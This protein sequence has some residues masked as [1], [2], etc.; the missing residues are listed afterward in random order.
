MEFSID[1]KVKVMDP[2]LMMLMSFMPPGTPPNN[3]GYIR[4]IDL[5]YQEAMI[6]FPIGDDPIEEHSQMS[7]YPLDML[8]LVKEEIDR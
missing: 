2:G 8:R 6:E 1:D 5:E 3:V 7:P 4:E